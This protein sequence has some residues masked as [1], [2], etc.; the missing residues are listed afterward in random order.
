MATPLQT[1]PRPSGVPDLRPPAERPAVA[2]VQAAVVFL[3]GMP[4]DEVLSYAVSRMDVDAAGEEF[5]WQLRRLAAGEI[6]ALV[7]PTRLP[8]LGEFFSLHRGCA[9]YLVEEA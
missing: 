3:Y 5:C 7:T 9:R 8:H 6:P 2:D 4:Y 1:T